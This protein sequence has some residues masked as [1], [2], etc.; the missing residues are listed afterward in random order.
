P[1]IDRSPNRNRSEPLGVRLES[2]FCKH[3]ARRQRA[4][5]VKS[6]AIEPRGTRTITVRV[7]AGNAAANTLDSLTHTVGLKG[8]ESLIFPVSEGRSATELQASGVGGSRTHT[9]TLKRRVRCLYATT[10]TGKSCV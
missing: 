5:C 4:K 6:S 10:P 3:F 7:R 1:P 9:S 8:V 2:A